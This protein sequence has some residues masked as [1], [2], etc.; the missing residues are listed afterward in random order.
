M[1]QLFTACNVKRPHEHSQRS[2]LGKGPPVVRREDV[3]VYR[4]REALVKVHFNVSTPSIYNILTGQETYNPK[5]GTALDII[6][7]GKEPY[8]ATVNNNLVQVALKQHQP[9][10]RLFLFTNWGVTTRTAAALRRH[11]GKKPDCKRLRI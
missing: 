5:V 6:I 7:A 2:K 10:P 3:Q 1:Q 4:D 11:E 8:I 9:L